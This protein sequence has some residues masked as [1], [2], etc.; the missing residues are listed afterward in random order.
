MG[1]G[2]EIM[3]QGKLRVILGIVDQNS[4]FEN[5]FFC[6]IFLDEFQCVGVGSKRPVARFIREQPRTEF[7]LN[8]SQ[9]RL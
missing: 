4:R 3:K 5:L 8:F 6:L 2:I 9:I 7:V 1:K